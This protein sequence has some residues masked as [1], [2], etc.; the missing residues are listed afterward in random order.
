VPY[1]R[2]PTG[3]RFDL[4]EASR[5]WRGPPDRP[6]ITRRSR[7]GRGH[8][9]TVNSHANSSA[10]LWKERRLLRAA[11]PSS[12]GCGPGPGQTHGV[13]AKVADDCPRY[14]KVI[15]HPAAPAALSA[16][17][18]RRRSFRLD[19]L[20]AIVDRL[21]VVGDGL[22][23][24][25]LPRGPAYGFRP[26]SR[27]A[28]PKDGPTSI[29]VR[30]ISRPGAEL[31]DI[32]GHVAIPSA[33]ARA[34]SNASHSPSPPSTYGPP[35]RHIRRKPADGTSGRLPQPGRTGQPNRGNC[36]LPGN[37]AAPIKMW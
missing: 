28:A 18:D 20:H 19:L 31:E 10:C 16:G 8:P 17:P 7:V 34:T 25:R 33:R 22:G 3:S 12:S 32:G 13:M 1:N 29:T 2:P 14:R 4:L 30:L 9:E 11:R 26:D 21:P 24:L 36:R 35:A 37:R 5:S 15:G 27:R 23:H 6:R